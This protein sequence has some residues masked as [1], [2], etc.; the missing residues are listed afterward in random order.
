MTITI[1]R[2]VSTSLVVAF[3][4]LVMAGVV[5]SQTARTAQLDPISAPGRYQIVINPTVRADTFLL[6]SE[7]GRVWQMTQYTN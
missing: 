1:D 4:F 2:R 5:V 6:D 7:T 3:L